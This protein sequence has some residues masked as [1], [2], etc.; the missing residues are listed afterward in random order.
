MSNSYTEIT[1]ELSTW[2]AAQHLFFVATAPLSPDGHVNCS[3][4]G[5]EAFRVLSPKA[6][7][8][9]D[10]TGSGAET[11]AHLREN[12]RIVFMFCE[13]SAAAKIVRLHGKGR[14]ILPESSEWSAYAHRFEPHPGARS[15]VLADVERVSDSCGFGVPKYEYVRQRKGLT[16]WAES[17]GAD[18]LAQYRDLKNTHSIDG[19]PG[20]PRSDAG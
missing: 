10:L 12:G 4:K 19:L 14:V 8:Y 3:P 16:T 18:G 1:P 17:K 13:M 5:L 6:V 7:A 9:L 11:I 15:I 2:I 20:L